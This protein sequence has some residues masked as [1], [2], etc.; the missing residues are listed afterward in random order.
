MPSRR[1]AA[2]LA[3]AGAAGRLPAASRR[4]RRAGR[5]SEL[6]ECRLVV[7]HAADLRHRRG[8]LHRASRPRACAAARRRTPRGAPF[9][10][11]TR[12]P[13]AWRFAGQ[14][15]ASG[16]PCSRA[17]R[18]SCPLDRKTGIERSWVFCGD[19]SAPPSTRRP[20]SR[21]RR[22]ATSMLR[23]PTPTMWSCQRQGSPV[24]VSSPARPPWVGSVR[25]RRLR[26]EPG[27]GAAATAPVVTISAVGA[28]AAVEAPGAATEHRLGSHARRRRPL[29]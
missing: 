15:L 14:R 19:S 18:Q 13:R 11:H 24:G 28:M 21:S 7:V 26:V 3:T 6:V 1:S 20:A 23:M 27:R 29:S 4:R 17:K 16:V 25:R 12:L 9:E 10:R 22:T 2:E 5:L 8:E